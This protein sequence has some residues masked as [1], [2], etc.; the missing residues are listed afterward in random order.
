M[1]PNEVAALIRAS[2]PEATVSVVS[3]DNTHFA[4]RVISTGFRGL[5]SIARHQ[6]VYRALGGRVGNE[7]H[8]LSIEAL[9]PEEA[10]GAGGMSGQP[11]GHTHG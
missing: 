6:A 8:A 5:R 7:I 2:L 3:E 9:T 1:N 11:P 4:A 10:A